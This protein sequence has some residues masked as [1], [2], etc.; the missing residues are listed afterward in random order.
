MFSSYIGKIH[1][2]LMLMKPSINLLVPIAWQDY[3]LLD[4]GNGAKLERYA[5]YRFVRP[6]PQAVWSPSLNETEWQRID[7]AF[8]PGKAENGGHWKLSNAAH[9]DPWE[10]VFRGIKFFAYV[11]KS[12]HM[13]VFP[14]QAP[15][16]EWISQEINQSTRQIQVLNLFGYTGIATLVA[17]QAGAK[18]THVD[19]SKHSIRLARENQNLAGMN[20]Y[21]IRWIVDD[22]LKFV[23][24]EVR[25]GIKY[26][27]IIM[28]PPKFG[29]G[30][31]GEVW[32]FFKLIPYLLESCRNILSERPSFIVI[33][34]Y[35]IQA[36]S[37]SLYYSV[38][39][40]FKGYGGELSC[41]ELALQEKSAG[42]LLPM[43]IYVRWNT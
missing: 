34:A 15:H 13:G 10:M 41:G 14:E 23:Q 5:R 27:A 21:P 28:D 25:R 37:L 18:V 7:G 4:S 38:E 32:E 8:Q 39:S 20:D 33:T 17:A 24:R 11:S 6:A 16:W 3:E 42:R 29:R 12:R 1:L 26:D 43:A 9:L 19:A 30:P 36:S 40:S 35:A 22:V 31:K 2:Q